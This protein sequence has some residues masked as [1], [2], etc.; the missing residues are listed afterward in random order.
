MGLL[1]LVLVALVT[2]W[3]QAV[4]AVREA[5]Q[6]VTCAVT[7]TG[8]EQEF[9]DF[10]RSAKLDHM[11]D[12]PIGVTKPKRWFFAPGGP[13][14]SAAWKQLAPGRQKGYWE[15]YKAEIAA[16]QLDKL[17]GMN[18]VPPTVDRRID[19]ELGAF[20]QWVEPVSAWDIDKPAQGPEPEWTRQVSRMKLFDQLTANI[21]RNEGN[22][23]Y[24]ADW[25]LILIDHSR[26]FTE[27]KD[28]RGITQ[29]GRIDAWLW[30]KIEALTLERLQGAL[31]PWLRKK[32][33]EA[34]LARR[35]RMR[36]AI[37]KLV[38]ERGEDKVFLR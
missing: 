5:P 13:I 7:W 10:L 3:P 19:Y 27:Q 24:D 34:I 12:V 36:A 38:A 30:D 11:E 9:E 37:A 2:A 6:T 8:H 18:M 28:L 32:E 14:R 21:D 15:S 4:A 20:Q 29:P 33:I 26:C 22:L 23:I 17:L 31:G 25:H 1:S 16:Y 35:D